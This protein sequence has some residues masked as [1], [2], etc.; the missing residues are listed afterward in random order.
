MPSSSVMMLVPGRD[1][2]HAC[3]ALSS[4]KK[5]M[6]WQKVETTSLRLDSRSGRS[7]D[8]TVEAGCT[9]STEPGETMSSMGAPVWAHEELTC[10]DRPRT[11]G[12]KRQS[13]AHQA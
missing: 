4:L 12:R 11:A 2:V 8:S 6:K 10:M 3:A 9:R 7:I 13:Q 5:W 1:A